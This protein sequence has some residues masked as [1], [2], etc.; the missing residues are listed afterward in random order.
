M[1]KVIIFLLLAALLLTGC[2]EKTKI[3]V[4]TENRT[5]SDGSHTYEYTDTADI[6]LRKR[7][8]HAQSLEG[9]LPLQ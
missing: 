8:H 1:K 7:P 4:D 2:A 5:I 9:K 6:C 3:V